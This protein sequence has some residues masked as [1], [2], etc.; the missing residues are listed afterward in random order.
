[1]E[2]N[3]TYIE[4]K[5][6]CPSCKTGMEFAIK[7]T[8][9]NLVDV[10]LSAKCSNCGTEILFTPSNIIGIINENK[11]EN[12]Y[13]EEKEVI[14]PLIEN[15]IDVETIPSDISSYF[16]DIDEEIPQERIEAEEMEENRKK[17]KYIND[18]FS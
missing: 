18:I 7:L 15:E 3:T 2:S 5:I 13:I 12:K 1:M 9:V 11:F 6:S 4:K 14:Q 16:E 17:R 8:N 10:K